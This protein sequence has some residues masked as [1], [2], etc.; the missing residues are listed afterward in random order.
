MTPTKTITPTQTPTT[1]VTPTKTP[2]PSASGIPS[3]PY[4]IFGTAQP[5][6]AD[7]RDSGGLDGIVVGLKFQ[8]TQPSG[9][10]TA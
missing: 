6:A 5:T 8:T 1:S 9:F 2:T 7:Y 4:T 3:T 10:I